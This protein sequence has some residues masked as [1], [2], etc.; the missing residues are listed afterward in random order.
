MKYSRITNPEVGLLCWVKI[1]IE[2]SHMGGNQFAPAQIEKI[3]REK[4]TWADEEEGKIPKIN[5]VELTLLLGGDTII[6]MSGN[7][8]A[9]FEREISST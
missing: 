8:L 9:I 6:L 7:N 1:S 5:S 2:G 4:L 3:N